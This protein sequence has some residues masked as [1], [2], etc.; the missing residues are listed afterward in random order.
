MAK[1]RKSAKLQKE[2]LKNR[3]QEK[4]FWTISIGVAV[5][6]LV[7]LYIVFMLNN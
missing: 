5:I 7:I 3:K 4:K 6:L 1:S 2:E